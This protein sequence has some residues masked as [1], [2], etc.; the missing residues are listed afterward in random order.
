MSCELL[1]IILHDHL[2]LFK[3][4]EHGIQVCMQHVSYFA[5]LSIYFF[6][7]LG[8]YNILLKIL[9]EINLFFR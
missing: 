9:K 8:L 2:S 7:P 5:F 4:P 1:T 3:F 6:F